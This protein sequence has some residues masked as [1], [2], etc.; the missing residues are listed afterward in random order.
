MAAGSNQIFRH[1][2]KSDKGISLSQYNRLLD[3]ASAVSRGGRGSRGRTLRIGGSEY[4]IPDPVNDGP[5]FWNNDAAL[6]IPAYGI[7]LRSGGGKAI[8]DGVVPNVIRPNTYGC[9]TNF[10]VAGNDP[11]DAQTMGVAQKGDANQYIIAYSTDG[12]ATPTPGEMWGPCSGQYTIRRLYGGFRIID[13]YDATNNLALCESMPMTTVKGKTLASSIPS[14]ASGPLTV[15]V[16]G[17]QPPGNPVISNVLNASSCTIK[18]NF[19]SRIMFNP[20][21]P[22]AIWQWTDAYTQ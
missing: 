8:D 9:Q 17:I 21:E 10:M 7:V 2:E 20:G 11:V 12:G 1:A 18:A 16:N 19:D 13:I 22:T 14:G 4:F 6:Q 5:L 3:V 15:Y